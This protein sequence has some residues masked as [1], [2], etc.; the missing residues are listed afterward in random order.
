MSAEQAKEYGLIDQ[1]LG[2]PYRRRA[3]RTRKQ[4]VVCLVYHFAFAT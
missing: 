2:S 4:V 1:I 3:A